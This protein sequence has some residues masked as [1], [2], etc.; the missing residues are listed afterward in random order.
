M[1][2]LWARG[3]EHVVAL[4]TQKQRVQRAY[5]LIDY[6]QLLE[7][8][9]TNDNNRC[10]DCNAPSPQWVRLLPFSALLPTLHPC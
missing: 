10:V 5:R 3:L 4:R 1:V 9:K 8:Q 6:M 7:I 2:A